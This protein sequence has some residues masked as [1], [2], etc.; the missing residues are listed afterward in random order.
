MLINKNYLTILG[1]FILAL[2]VQNISFHETP[3]HPKHDDEI[4]VVE[5]AYNIYKR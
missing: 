1:I 4:A 5:T 3:I 2:I